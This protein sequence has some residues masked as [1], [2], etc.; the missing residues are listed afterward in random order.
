VESY[1]ILGSLGVHT[2]Y[3]IIERGVIVAT[4]ISR[5]DGTEK[6]VPVPLVYKR[7]PVETAEVKRYLFN[8]PLPIAVQHNGEQPRRP[9]WSRAGKRA[10]P[11]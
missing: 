4:Q 7:K 3:G 10:A 11:C 1:C 6:P 5:P 9:V 8:N 2:R